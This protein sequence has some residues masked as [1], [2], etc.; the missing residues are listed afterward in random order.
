MSQHHNYLPAS[1]IWQVFILC[2]QRA[3]VSMETAVNSAGTAGGDGPTEDCVQRAPWRAGRQVERWGGCVPAGVAVGEA[4][5]E[6]SQLQWPGGVVVSK[7][8][9][10]M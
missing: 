9:G 6:L 8:Q 10:A 7:P 5:G 1:F 4:Q 3:S 2:L